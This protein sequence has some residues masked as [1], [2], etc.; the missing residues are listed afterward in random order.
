MDPMGFTT[1]KHSQSQLVKNPHGFQN[2]SPRN[3]GGAG[4]CW[5]GGAGTAVPA[6]R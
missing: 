4:G 3:A 5:F 1:G 6:C 2:V